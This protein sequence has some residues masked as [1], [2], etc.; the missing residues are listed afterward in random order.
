LGRQARRLHAE[1]GRPIVQAKVQLLLT[2]G[3]L[4][5]IAAKAVRESAEH[6]MQI[7]CYEDVTSICNNLHK[8]IKDYDIILIK[9]SRVAKLET[10]IE[11]LKELFSR[12]VSREVR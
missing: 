7:K 2:V 3:E 5:E 9:G 8:F 6:D 4:A 12:S 10:V 11:K 1:L